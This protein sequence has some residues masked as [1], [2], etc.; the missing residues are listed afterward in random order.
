VVLRGAD[1][2]A[3]LLTKGL[4]SFGRNDDA[5]WFWVVFDEEL[6]VE[7]RVERIERRCMVVSLGILRFAQN[8]GKELR[9]PTAKSYSG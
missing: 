4:S 8:D 3:V 1:F 7:I 9:R 6:R 5:F 2:S